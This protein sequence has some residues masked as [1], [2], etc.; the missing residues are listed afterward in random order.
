M[1][2]INADDFAYWFGRIIGKEKIK[3]EK[4]ERET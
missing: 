1:R 2:I 4:D 3:K